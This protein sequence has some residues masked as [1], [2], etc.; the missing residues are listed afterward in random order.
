MHIAKGHE[1]LREVRVQK[2]GVHSAGEH[3]GKREELN[4]V[5]N[6]LYYSVYTAHSRKIHWGC[7]A[8]RT[9]QTYICNVSRDG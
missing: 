4:F 9:T 5:A 2:T 6:E 8:G 3:N 7:W 1:D